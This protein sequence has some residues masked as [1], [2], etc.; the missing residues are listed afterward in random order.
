MP[1]SLI[2][3][4]ILSVI[5][6]RMTEAPVVVLQGARSVGKSTMLTELAR[7]HDVE[8]TDLDDPAVRTRVAASPSDAVSGPVPVC[9]DEY[10]HVPELLQAIKAELN[11][12]HDNGRW[13]LTGSASFW[14]MPRGT[15][16]LTGRLQLVEVMPFSQGELDGVHEDFLDVVF[17]DPAALATPSRVVTEREDYEQ[18]A[19]RGGMPLAVQVEARRR[20]N[21]YRGYLGASLQ[22]DILDLSRVRQVNVLPRLM[23][24]LA[25]QT[26]QVLNI[27]KASNG[28]G[29][30]P[31]S[32]DNYVRL[33]EALFLIRRLPAWGRTLRSRTA[34][35]PKLHVVDSGLAAYLLGVTPEK[36]ARR[37]PAA[38]SEFGH[39]F[40][41]F[42]VGEILKQAS[43]RDDI[44]DLGHWR[45]HNDQEVDLVA[46][47]IDGRVVGFEIKAGREVDQKGLRGLIALR[48]ALGDQF[49]AGFFLNTGTEAYRIDDRIYVCPIDRLWQT[50]LN[51][52]HSTN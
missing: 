49:H 30:E 28:A 25:A 37:D 27:V 50:N 32:G 19:C 41:T 15:Q 39:L 23:E 31:R 34:H 1:S 6:D 29:I 9:I 48:D 45:T 36:L 43:W 47:T 21:F 17:I 7:R 52:T 5:V 8:I 24:R 2:E 4:R 12:R 44:R 16:A 10:Q 33:L 20:A 42:V 14:A 35:S 51:T 46:E 11:K 22:R 26:G 38:L 40:E 3:R 18:R 13:L